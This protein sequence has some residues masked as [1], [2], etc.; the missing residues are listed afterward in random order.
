MV[1]SSDYIQ[2]H[3]YPLLRSES[4]VTQSG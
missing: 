2:S 4:V 1:T 3:G